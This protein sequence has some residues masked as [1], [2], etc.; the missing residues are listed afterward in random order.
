MSGPI[1][2]KTKAIQLMKEELL[3]WLCINHATDGLITRPLLKSKALEF[4]NY[5]GVK[6][7]L[8]IH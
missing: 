1:I 5:Y 3:K 8:I 6:G 7:L 2:T 4:V